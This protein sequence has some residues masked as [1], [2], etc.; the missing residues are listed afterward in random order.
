MFPEPIRIL[1]PVEGGL[2]VVADATYYLEGLNIDGIRIKTA[3][4][5]SAVPGTGMQA[6]GEWFNLREPLPADVAFWYS[7]QGAVIGSTGGKVIPLMDGKIAGQEYLSG[8]SFFVE[9]PSIRQVGTVLSN[10]GPAS[11]LEAVDSATAV[12]RRNGV[13]IG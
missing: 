2:Y 9:K 1:E 8:A 7:S 10:P 5:Y 4:P 6:R 11:G 13:I 3:Y 12:V